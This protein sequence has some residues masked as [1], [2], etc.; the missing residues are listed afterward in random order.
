M[1][2]SSESFGRRTS[3]S[4]GACAAVSCEESRA[5][6]APKGPFYPLPAGPEGPAPVRPRRALE[7]PVVWSGI[8]RVGR[9]LA[10]LQPAPPGDWRPAEDRRTGS[11]RSCSSG[12]RAAR[13]ELREGRPST[14]GCEQPAG[15]HLGA[16]RSAQRRSRLPAHPSPAVR[17]R[18]S[19][20]LLRCLVASAAPHSVNQPVLRG[21]REIRPPGRGAW[22]LPQSAL[23]GGPGAGPRGRGLRRCSPAEAGGLLRSHPEGWPGR[24]H[25]WGE[26]HPDPEGPGSDSARRKRRGSWRLAR[27]RTG[28]GG[29]HALRHV[30]RSPVGGPPKREPDLQLLPAFHLP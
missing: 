26:P 13:K 16:N 5:R 4:W 15:E 8:A 27:R 6:S 17:L 21:R 9:L 1:S 12:R 7:G 18:G 29:R 25:E 28:P 2:G 19:C 10:N 30:L 24:C 20:G 22:T 14:C 3:S 23:A 11:R